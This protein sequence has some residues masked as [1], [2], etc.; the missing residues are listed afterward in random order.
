MT[1]DNKWTRLVRFVDEQGQERLGQPVDEK[2]DVGLA[3]AAGEKVEAF[4]ISGDIYDGTVT[5]QKTTIVKLLSP[6]SR[7]DVSIIRCLG[8]NFMG[9]WS[10][11]T[12]P[13]PSARQ[14]SQQGHSE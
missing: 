9:E 14:G 12:S 11:R 10:D 13:N 4:L 7:N 1:N 8:L 2:I 6:V 5:P 3:I